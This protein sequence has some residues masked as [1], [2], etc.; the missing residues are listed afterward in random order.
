MSVTAQVIGQ[1]R[2]GSD[3]AGPAQRRRIDMTGFVMIENKPV[4]RKFA[5]KKPFIWAE[6]R[7]DLCSALPYYQ[8]YQS[9]AYTKDGVMRG[10]LLDAFGGHR[11]IVH[12]DGHVIMTV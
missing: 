4:E 1:T 6:K 2:K 7:Q 3:M 10:N 12:S 8:A 5:D 9:G 11:D